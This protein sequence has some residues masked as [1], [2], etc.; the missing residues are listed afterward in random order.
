[1]RPFCFQ[2]DLRILQIRIH[3]GKGRCRRCPPV[4]SVLPVGCASSAAH[5]FLQHLSGGLAVPFL[6][7]V[8]PRLLQRLDSRC[9]RSRCVPRRLPCQRPSDRH[10][11]EPARPCSRA[12]FR[13]ARGH[14]RPALRF[15]RSLRQPHPRSSSLPSLR[16]VSHKTAGTADAAAGPKAAQRARPR[17]NAPHAKSARHSGIASNL[18]E[19]PCRG[20]RPTGPAARAAA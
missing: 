8:P 12:A 7:V 19:P 3:S 4:H 16:S 18:R 14:Q 17:R 9:V 10:Q 11:S 20:P 1:M 5:D 13:Q 6:R 2:K 15:C